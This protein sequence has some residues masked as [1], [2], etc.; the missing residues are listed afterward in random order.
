MEWKLII[1]WSMWICEL[2]THTPWDMIEPI[3]K[4]RRNNKNKKEFEE[5]TNWE[6]WSSLCERDRLFCVYT[7][8][9]FIT[10]GNAIWNSM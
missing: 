3:R 10:F 4:N 9:V 7:L 2:N 6:E 1:I 8:H 5:K